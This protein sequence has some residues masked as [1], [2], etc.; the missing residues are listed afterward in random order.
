PPA[1]EPTAGGAPARVN[2]SGTAGAGDAGGTSGPTRART[3]QPDPAARTAGGDLPFTGF[4]AGLSGSAGGLL[5]VFGALLRRRDVQAARR[6]QA[7]AVIPPD[8]ASPR[9]PGE[10][11]RGGEPVPPA[12]PPDH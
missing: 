1:S 10:R 7:L 2:G 3:A 8:E 4:T 9:D 5:L 6:R 12:A 11:C